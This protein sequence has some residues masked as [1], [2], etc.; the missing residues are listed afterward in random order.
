MCNVALHLVVAFNLWSD[1]L[2]MGQHVIFPDD[3]CL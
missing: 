2:G 1:L 3:I